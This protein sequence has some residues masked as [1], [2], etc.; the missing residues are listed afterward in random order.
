MGEKADMGILGFILALLAIVIGVGLAGAIALGVAAKKGAARIADWGRRNQIA[1]KVSEQLEEVKASPVVRQLTGGGAYRYL[2]P[3]AAT[4]RQVRGTL[5]AFRLDPVTGPFASDAI[6][7]VDK[8]DFYR[9]ALSNT[10]SSE[11]GEGSLTWAKFHVP[12]SDSVQ[13]VVSTSARMANRIQVFDTAAYERLSS[14]AVVEGSVDAD[15]LL[16]M[17]ATLADLGRMRDTSAHLLSGLER[18]LGE[19][20]AL[21]DARDADGCAYLLDELGRLSRDA[22]LYV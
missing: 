15:A 21:P 5:A 9:Q 14:S 17:E 8:A 12:V 11:F 6:E 18:L 3:D 2:D 1:D 13:S 7:A 4:P 10:L 19:L 16:D 20:S 22:K